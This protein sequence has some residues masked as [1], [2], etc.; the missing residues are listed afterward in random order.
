MDGGLDTGGGFLS[1]HFSDSDL[2]S[3]PE[4]CDET[5]QLGS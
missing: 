2:Q 3:D 5:L 1:E 4:R